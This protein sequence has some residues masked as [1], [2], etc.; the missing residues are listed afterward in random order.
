MN[1]SSPPSAAHPPVSICLLTYGDFPDL[2]RQSLGS[3][4]LNCE[5]SLYR[6]IVGANSPGPETLRLLETLETQGAIDRLI[7]SPVNLNKSPMMRRMFAG[8]QTEFIWWFDDDSSVCDRLALSQRLELARAA[9]PATVLWGQE[10]FCDSPLD[11]WHGHNAV[12]FV[13]TA[14]WYG[15][16][17]PPYWAPGGKGE[18]NHDGQ[19]G[20]NGRW[21]FIVGG[22]WFGRASAIR[23][24]D[25]P[26][27]RL[28]K[29]GEDV[30]LGEAIRQQG[31]RFQNIGPLGTRINSFPRRGDI[32]VALP[33]PALRYGNEE[34][35]E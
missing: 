8:L 13:R 7:I 33:G 11:F 32:G 20:G 9:D 15:G 16:L 10:A 24:L 18:F 12:E 17:T 14:S 2:A 31:W 29:L 3:I 27:P 5:R 28:V 6:L 25:W 4:S 21:S 34:R 26:D 1:S 30:L 23:Q 22:S 35:V 19:S